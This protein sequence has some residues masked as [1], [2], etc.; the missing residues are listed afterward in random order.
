MHPIER[1]RHV[2]RAT[3]ADP[4]LLAREA[5]GALVSFHDDPAGLVTACRRLIDRHVEVGPLWWL[6]AR[7]LVADDISA[8]AWASSRLLDEDDTPR[9]LAADL[10]PDTTVVVMGWPDVAASAL[11]LR[12]D[13]EILVV[14]TGGYGRA[15]SSRLAALDVSAVEVPEGGV[16]P[17]VA[18]AG[19]V[20]LEA[21]ALGPTGLVAPTG[22]YAAAAVARH[23]GV[24]I[25]AVAGVGRVL[26]GRLWEALTGRLAN[27]RDEAWDRSVEVVPAD[28]VDMVTGPQATEP[29]ADACRRADCPATPELLRAV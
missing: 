24:P 5:A 7:V 17:A 20:L 25:W 3:G 4:S 22:S 15:F 6:A 12:G 2:A 10:P 28:V 27:G 8:E 18:E 1:L 9:Q 14:D 23:A 16:G 13:L 29:F 21:T 11:A 26:P 19:L